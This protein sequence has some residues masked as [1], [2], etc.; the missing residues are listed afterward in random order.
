MT[1]PRKIL[2]FGCSL[3]EARGNSGRGD[4]IRLAL[5][6]MTYAGDGRHK[7]RKLSSRS[8]LPMETGL[9]RRG[10]GLRVERGR[11]WAP[12]TAAPG[13][14]GMSRGALA[15][16]AI[17]RAS[18]GLRV[19]SG[20]GIMAGKVLGTDCE[21]GTMAGADRPCAGTP[22]DGELR[23]SMDW[24]GDG[25]DRLRG[26]GPRQG[27]WMETAKEKGGRGQGPQGAMSISRVET[28]SLWTRR[29]GTGSP[30]TGTSWMGETRAARPGKGEALRPRGQYLVGGQCAACWSRHVACLHHQAGAQAEAW[31]QQGAGVGGDSSGGPAWPL[32]SLGWRLESCVCSDGK[33]LSLYLCSLFALQY[34]RANNL[35]GQNPETLE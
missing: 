10:T 12:L 7:S 8:D 15:S 2:P 35:P 26:G 14:A 25:R 13:R 6:G 34:P 24:A 17:K 30:G 3:R 23:V 5:P 1:S 18:V 9:G 27:Y 19:A 11:G 31:G 20:A 29:A 32:Q 4:Q 21:A 28:R 33:M 16:R 22:E